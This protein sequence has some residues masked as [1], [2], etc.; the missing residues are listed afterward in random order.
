MKDVKT[1]MEYR[2]IINKVDDNLK[3]EQAVL[4]AKELEDKNIEA[5]MTSYR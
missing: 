3:L 2:V 1:N 4:I 5:I